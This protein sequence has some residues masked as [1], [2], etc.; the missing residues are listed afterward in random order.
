RRE[1]CSTATTST[2]APASCWPATATSEIAAP[3]RKRVTGP[4]YASGAVSDA[5]DHQQRSDGIAG[6]QDAKLVPFEGSGVGLQGPV[7]PLRPGGR[8]A[9]ACRPGARA[10]SG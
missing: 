7:A 1:G 2:G 10:A 4:P 8:G 3:W 9:R 5:D 6:N